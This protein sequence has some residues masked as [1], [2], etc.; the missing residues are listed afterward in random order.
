MS[1]TASLQFSGIGKQFP[2]VQALADISFIA[3][4]G[5][6]HALMG[7][8]GAGKS[9]L[10][11]ILGGAYQP[12][13][14]HL[15]IGEQSLTFK[16]TAESIASGVAVIHQELHLVPEMTVA[17]NLF[18]GHLPARFGLSTAAYCAS[19]RWTCSRAWPTKSIRRK[20]SRACRWASAN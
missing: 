14:G 16:S 6:V 8:N 19:K 4:P 20:R 15:Q 5:Q 3:H 10:L 17:E 11:K 13:S 1:S 18:L 12:S 9:T 2:G 7:E